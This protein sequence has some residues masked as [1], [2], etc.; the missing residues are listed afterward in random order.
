MHKTEVP[1]WSGSVE[2]LPVALSALPATAVVMCF[3]SPVVDLS[4]IA[5]AGSRCSAGMTVNHFAH[6][7]AGLERTEHRIADM[8]AAVASCWTNSNATISEKLFSTQASS[9]DTEV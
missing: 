4:S 7:T 8:I 1:R 9:A 6:K 5:R 3:G 2:V